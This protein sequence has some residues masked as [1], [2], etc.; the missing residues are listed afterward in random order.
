M[1]LLR[2]KLGFTMT[3][4]GYHEKCSGRFNIDL[5]VQQRFKHMQNV[6]FELVCDDTVMSATKA[7][8]E[9]TVCILHCD[10][11]L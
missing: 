10:H 5:P 7:S 4:F 9:L 6:V 11:I 2:L 8:L 1:S 3:M